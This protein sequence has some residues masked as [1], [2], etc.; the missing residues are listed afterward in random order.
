MFFCNKLEKLL[1]NLRWESNEIY[2]NYYY[3][4]KK[5]G[6]EVVLIQVKLERLRKSLGNKI[7]GHIIINIMNSLCM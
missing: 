4:Y 2:S 7:Q 3:Y 6:K 5:R 1:F